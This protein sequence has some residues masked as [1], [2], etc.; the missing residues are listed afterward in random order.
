M[1]GGELLVEVWGDVFL[2]LCVV[3]GMGL[4][5]FIDVVMLLMCML[6]V[7]CDVYGWLVVV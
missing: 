7:W 2:M 1:V 3:G 6:W 4:F 5:K